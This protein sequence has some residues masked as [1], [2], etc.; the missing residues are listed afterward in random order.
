MSCE[1]NV[2]TG[3]SNDDSADE[4]DRDVMYNYQLCFC[5]Y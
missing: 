2:D 5:C 3:I 1:T 4:E